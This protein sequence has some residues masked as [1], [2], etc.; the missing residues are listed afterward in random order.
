MSIYRDQGIENLGIRGD[1]ERFFAQAGGLSDKL[2]FQDKSLNRRLEVAKA[3]R[4]GQF[5]LGKDRP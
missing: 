3:E 5:C 1:Y 2:V 4:L